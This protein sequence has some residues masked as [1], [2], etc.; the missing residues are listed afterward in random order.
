MAETIIITSNEPWEDVWVSKHHYANELTKLGYEV[1]FVDPPP[2]WNLFNLFS[3]S[4]KKKKLKE[5]L[6]LVTYKNNFPIRVFKKLFLR[7][8]DYLNAWKISKLISEKKNTIWWQFDPFR[9]VYTDFFE[10][11]RRIYHVVDPYQHIW[12]DKKIAAKADLL[13]LISKEYCSYYS[14]LKKNILCIPHGISQEEYNITE[15]LTEQF[16]CIYGIYIL[17]AG[18][19]ANDINIDLLSDIAANFSNTLLLLGPLKLT[20]EKKIA[21]YNELLKNNN[22]KWIGQKKADELKNYI[23]ASAICIVPYHFENEGLRASS[24]KIMNYIAQKKI[25]ITTK[26][27]GFEPLLGKGI[28]C[29]TDERAFISLIEK[30]LNND[31]LCDEHEITEYLKAVQYPILIDRILKKLNEG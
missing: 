2:K 5:G 19:I 31:L 4:G 28:Y 11:S 27:S 18:T 21:K 9:F 14:S 7:V 29:A 1:Y 6:Y 12:S 26:S 8:N 17:F 30:G 15:S 16:R 24:L 13:I 22:V 25:V 10:N 20:D 23:K 3:F